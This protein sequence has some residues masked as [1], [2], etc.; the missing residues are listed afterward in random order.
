MIPTDTLA[1]FL[2]A[3]LLLCAAPGPDNLFV[4]TQAAL[5]G[6][7]AGL[8][9]MAGLCVGLLGHT[10][11]VALGIAAMFQASPLAFALLK[12]AG[13]A[14]LLW[15][16]WQ[17]FRTPLTGMASTHPQAQT[18]GR[19]FRRG[20]FMNLTNPKVLIFFL[21]FLPQFADPARGPVP[22]QIALL[23]GLFIAS[24]VLVFGAI[25]WL[26]GSLS[27]RLLRSPRAHRWLQRAAAAIFVALALRLLLG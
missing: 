6:R 18:P 10:A 13:A 26:S 11:L 4:L 24:T 5:H 25:A 1:T 16:A 12:F 27:H 2:V 7:A 17:A 23:G 15:L 3:S 9:V 22:L 8:R 19:L 21:A 20:I 14:Y